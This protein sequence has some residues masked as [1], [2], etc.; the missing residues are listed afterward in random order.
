VQRPLRL[1]LSGHTSSQRSA[2]ER[3]HLRAEAV[4]KIVCACRRPLLVASA[5]VG[6]VLQPTTAGSRWPLLD[7]LHDNDVTRPYDCSWLSS[8]L[9]K[10]NHK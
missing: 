3:G 10:R 4:H 1:L 5:Q 7:R 9:S 2:I 6:D 8:N